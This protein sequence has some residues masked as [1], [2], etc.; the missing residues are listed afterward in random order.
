MARSLGPFWGLGRETARSASVFPPV[1]IHDDGQSF[2]VRAEIPGLDRDALEVSVKGD[3]LILKGERK[4]FEAKDASY[5]RRECGR[6]QFSRAVT[7]PQPV[8]ADR[9]SATYQNGVLEIVL[10]R[11]PQTQPRRIAV[12]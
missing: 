9:I 2:L 1:N 5:H 7:L 12:H 4:A 6:G 11:S 8:D 10:P 3:E